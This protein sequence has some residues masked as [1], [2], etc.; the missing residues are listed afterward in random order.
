MTGDAIDIREF[1][2][3][4]LE[5]IVEFSLRAWEPVFASARAVLE[6]EIVLR[7]HPDWRTSQGETVRSICTS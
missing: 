6:D 5:A 2:E 4:D 7:L 3:E 1:A